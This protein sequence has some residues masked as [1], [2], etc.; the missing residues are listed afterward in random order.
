[1]L[2]WTAL[3]LRP[4]RIYAMATCWKTGWGTRGKIEVRT[5]AEPKDAV[6]A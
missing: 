5:A 6:P 4:L 1:M 3:V 2:V